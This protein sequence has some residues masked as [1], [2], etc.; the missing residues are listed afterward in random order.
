MPKLL[1]CTL[2]DGGYYNAWDFDPDLIQEYLN[3]MRFAGVEYVEFGFR[4][5]ESAGFMGGCAYSTDSYISKFLLPDSLKLSIMVNGKELLD[6]SGNVNFVSLD[7][8]FKPASE[9]AVSLVR[10]ATHFRDLENVLP[11][12]KWLK[13]AGYMVAVNLMQIDDRNKQDLRWAACLISSYPVDVLYFADSLGSMSPGRTIEIVR[14]LRSGWAGDLGIHAHDNMSRAVTNSV[15]A[16]EAGVTWVDGTITGMGRGPGNAK[17]ELLVLEFEEEGGRDRSLTD[18]LRL[19]RRRFEPMQKEYGWGVNAFYYLA[20]KYGIHPTF[21]Q[22]MLNDPRYEEEDVLSVIDYLKRQGGK[23][24]DATVLENAQ[25][26]YTS[27]PVGSWSPKK[28]FR[29]RD[30]LI[31]GNGPGIRRYRSDI[32]DYIDAKKPIVVALNAQRQIED[33]YIDIRIACHPLRLL[34]DCEKYRSYDQPLITPISQLPKDV[35]SR[36]DDVEILDYGITVKPGCFELNE[37]CATI[38]KPLVFVYALAAISS[39]GARRILLAGFDG[40][41]PGDPRN[42]EMD[43]LILVF[44]NTKGVPELFAITPTRYK[45]ACSSVYAM[46]GGS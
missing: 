11:A 32:E 25:S 44:S 18:L 4:S 35:A 34:A 14:T 36:L 46:S 2:R 42:I 30:V 43:E 40:Y 37:V 31:V 1:D 3:A 29:D 21:I 7:K 5:L 20:G 28:M 10:I 13:E 38:P 17:T 45:V 26:F 16:V 15:T 39:G 12:T 9:S 6:Q 41:S 23:K 33:D 8:L 22:N 27:P 19:V 24:F